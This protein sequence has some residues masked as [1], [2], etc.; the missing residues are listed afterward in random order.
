MPKKNSGFS[1][2]EVMVALAIMAIVAA[3]AIPRLRKRPLPLDQQMM[4][5]LNN[6][7]RVAQL[8]ALMTQKLHRLL[9]DLKLDRVQL[10]VDS[11][12]RDSRGVIQFQP[13][14]TAYT[15][16]RFALPSDLA[17]EGFWVKGKNLMVEG[18]GI[19]STSLWL[20]IIPEGLAQE[21]TIDMRQRENA[22]AF[23]LIL[24]PFTAQ[25]SVA[26]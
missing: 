16:T 5:E 23:S 9:F 7:T 25:F 10:E 2:I 14:K 11:G 20:Y 3:I 21:T 12:K 19:R 8:N 6:L 26:P 17:I 1:L 18:E 24:N 13:V 22:R 15:K 4:R